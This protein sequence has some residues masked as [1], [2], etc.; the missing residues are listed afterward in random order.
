MDGPRTSEGNG[1]DSYAD[2]DPDPAISVTAFKL[3]E[4]PK[5]EKG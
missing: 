1:D 5:V 2:R 4:D 3:Q